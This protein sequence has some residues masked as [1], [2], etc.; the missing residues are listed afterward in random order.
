MISPP[1]IDEPCVTCKVLRRSGGLT[2]RHRIDVDLISLN[3]DKPTVLII[4][5]PHFIPIHDPSAVLEWII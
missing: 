5:C 4:D 2:C 1:L 3:A